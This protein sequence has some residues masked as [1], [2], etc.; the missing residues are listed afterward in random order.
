MTETCLHGTTE[1]LAPPGS[2]LFCACS[3]LQVSKFVSWQC[4]CGPRKL[5]KKR[6][7]NKQQKT[8][9]GRWR[10]I[11]RTLSYLLEGFHSHCHSLFLSKLLCNQ[12]LGLGGFQ[13]Q[14]L[15]THAQLI[16]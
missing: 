11:L 10:L 6:K 16:Y 2:L 13:V 14:N 7:K 3:E 12:I 9:E 5:L 15:K 8:E 1:K 4:L